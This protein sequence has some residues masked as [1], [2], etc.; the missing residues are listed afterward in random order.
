[1]LGNVRQHRAVVF[2]SGLHMTLQNQPTL[3]KI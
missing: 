2:E 1:M 3:I